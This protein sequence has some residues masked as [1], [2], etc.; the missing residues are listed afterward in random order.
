MQQ[1]SKRVRLMTELP[2]L[3]SGAYGKVVTGLHRG[4]PCAIKLIKKTDNEVYRKSLEREVEALK[5]IKDPNV[6]VMLGSARHPR[7]QIKLQLCSQ[8]TFE[9]LISGEVLPA[10]V[11]LDY[12]RQLTGGLAAIHSA[13]FMHRDIK[14]IN[15]LVALDGG[16]RIA[17]FGMARKAD[18]KCQT[19]DVCTHNYK[20]PELLL[21]K[22][23]SYGID[24]WAMGQVL[25]STIGANIDTRV[26]YND[27]YAAQ[28]MQQDELNAIDDGY[29]LKTLCKGML[30]LEPKERYTARVCYEALRK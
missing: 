8:L 17:D 16:L 12:G 1:K 24:I 22:I 23:Y 2:V 19:Q 4:V 20:A 29:P 7:W 21:G 30:K 26:E 10:S 9:H 18:E 14:P 11:I 27:L 3:G 28:V 6:I 15:I 25:L 5:S 13:G